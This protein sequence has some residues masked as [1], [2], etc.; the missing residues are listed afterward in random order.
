MKRGEKPEVKEKHTH[1]CKN[2][3]A[4]SRNP[5]KLCKPK[6]RDGDE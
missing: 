4:G 3:G 1:I 5:N 2:C 6:K